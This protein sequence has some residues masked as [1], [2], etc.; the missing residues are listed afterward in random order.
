MKARIGRCASAGASIRLF[1]FGAVLMGLILGLSPVAVA[2]GYQV[3]VH[4]KG[5]TEEGTTLFA[6]NRNFNHPKIVEVDMQ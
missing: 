1:L 3:S 5:K 6:D 2:G 4:E